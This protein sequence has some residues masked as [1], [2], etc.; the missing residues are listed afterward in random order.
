MSKNMFALAP[1]VLGG[2]LLSQPHDV[3]AQSVNTPANAKECTQAVADAKEARTSEPELGPKAAKA[4]DEII[5]LAEKR[6]AQKEF[7]F[8]G[9]LLT[10]ARGMVASE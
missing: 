6:C 10:L 2:F 3:A 1:L 5:A 9:D 4:F 8:A 7:A